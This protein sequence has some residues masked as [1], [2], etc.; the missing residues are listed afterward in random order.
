MKI[1]PSKKASMILLLSFLSVTLPVLAQTKIEL[2]H[3]SVV[4]NQEIQDGKIKVIINYKPI[5]F[6]A[7][8]TFDENNLKYKI[9]Y[10]GVEKV[11]E[12]TSTVYTGSV[13]LQD[14][15][16]N[17]S[18][19]VIIETYSGGAHCCTNFNIYS[20]QSNQ[21]I[22]TETGYSDGNGGS[23]T[24]LNKDGEIEFVTYDNAFLYRFSAYAASFPP[25]QILKFHNGEFIPVTRQYPTLLKSTAWEMY[26]AYLRAKAE[27]YDVNGILAGYVAQKILLGEFQDGWNFML[28]NY[29]RTSDWGLE[30]YEGEN[31]VGK[32]NNFPTAL[33]AFLIE[34]GYLNQ[35]GQ[36]LVN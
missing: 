7:E 9:L 10:D 15:D 34:Q 13:S 26:Q 31:E 12:E 36:P 33:K 32:Y 5:N 4:Q 17:N 6:E 25:T 11:S 29:D 8:E 27:D 1:I 21:F 24:D 2:N 30:I 28:A 3:E 18:P 35:N 14:L 22:N 20:W 19:E 23:F 16:N